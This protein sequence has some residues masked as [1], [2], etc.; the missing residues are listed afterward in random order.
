MND[1]KQG[2]VRFYRKSI[3]SSVWK[4][5]NVWFVW[6]WCLFKSNHEDT[7]FPFNGEDM[8]VKKGQFITGINKAISELPTLSPQNYRTA[9]NYLKSTGIITI[10]SNNKFSI[11]VLQHF[12]AVSGDFS[13][14]F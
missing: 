9:I 2:W 14:F 7:K 1:L 6:S 13:K 3:D 5:P 12:A 8:E 10:K 4:N 11:I